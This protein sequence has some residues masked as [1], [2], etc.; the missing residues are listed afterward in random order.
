M[1]RTEF[2]TQLERLLQS[3][4][5]SERE[6]ALQYY[7]D[8]F[9]DAGAENEQEVIEA[10]GNP[11]RVAENIK[12]D[13][14]GNP[15]E[16]TAKAAPSDRAVIEYGKPEEEKGCEEQTSA[17]Q[18]ESEDGPGERKSIPAAFGGGGTENG[19]SSGRD[20]R[21]TE[22]ASGARAG[23][24]GMP[25]WAVALITVCV[26]FASPVLLC[27]AGAAL[28]LVFGVLMTWLAL[29]FAFGL[30]ALIL[31][32]MLAVLAAVGIQCMF[33]D[34]LVGVALIG[35]GLVC[36]GIGILF[37]MLTVALSGII[38][39]AIFRGIGRLFRRR[40]REAAV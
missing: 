13:I 38:T 4:S 21:Y 34:P 3:I 11:A 27:L 26:V 5:P 28:L 19:P 1:N 9:D 22:E 39:P 17:R 16:N 25:G 15:G 40:K 6:E 32:V 36:G 37:L 24:R 2:M 7:N 20:A 29:V 33:V 12:R 10:L 23:R 35:G 30:V 14:L 31:F 8:Y 18:P